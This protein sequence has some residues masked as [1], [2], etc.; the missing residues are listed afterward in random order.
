MLTR[1]KVTL[2]HYKDY[3]D[4]LLKSRTVRKHTSNEK[5]TKE[6]HACF[7]HYSTICQE[8]KKKKTA[9]RTT[10]KTNAIIS[11]FQEKFSVEQEPPQNSSVALKELQ[12][13]LEVKKK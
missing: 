6:Q 2:S 12:Y 13:K 7:L 11:K 4:I 5:K 3:H 8:G 10:I 9:T 1:Q